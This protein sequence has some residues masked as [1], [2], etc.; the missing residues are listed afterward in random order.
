[1]ARVDHDV[2]ATWN[3][4]PGQSKDFPYASPNP[5]ALHRDAELSRCGKA[6]PAV[7]KTIR[8]HKDNEGA[9]YFL[10]APFVN[11]LKFSG[12]PELQKRRSSFSS[13]QPKRACVPCRA[14]LSKPT[15]RLSFSCAHESHASLPAAC[16]WVGMFFVAFPSAPSN[17]RL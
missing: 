5:I 17:L 1:M 7:L 11:R 3:G 4:F 14:G 16:C 9:R 12:V 2:D 15:G 13:A 6:D 8:E 10:C